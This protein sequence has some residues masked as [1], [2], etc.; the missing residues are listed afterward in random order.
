[1]KLRLLVVGIV[2]AQLVLVCYGCFDSDSHERKPKG[3]K[4]SDEYADQRS[5]KKG[6]TRFS[7]DESPKGRSDEWLDKKDRSDEWL[8]SDEWAKKFSG[9]NE[10]MKD[11]SDDWAK[12]FSGSNEHMKDRSDEWAKKFSGSD[13]G[14]QRSD[15]G[16]SKKFS[17]S[18]KSS[19]G[20]SD[21]WL[22]SGEDWQRSDDGWSKKF[23]G[24]DGWQKKRSDDNEWRAKL[25]KMDT[26]P[27]GHFRNDQSKSSEE[28]NKAPRQ[29][30][31]ANQ[32]LPQQPQNQQS[33]QDTQQVAGQPQNQGSPDQ[34]QQDQQQ[35]PASASSTSTRRLAR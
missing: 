30:P 28:P 26:P 11:R 25:F 8:R 9:S 10:H 12:K 23:S 24:D 3:R 2:C 14:W 19:K 33:W 21:E 29:P 6:P 34:P 1:M 13:E 15:E 20:R 17:D 7:S 27:R 16:W 4:V 18:K 32:G 31:P 22:R 35:N 5:G